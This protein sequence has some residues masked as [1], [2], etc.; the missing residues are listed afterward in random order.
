MTNQQNAKTE[1]FNEPKPASIRLWHW[2]AFLFFLASITTVIIGST[3]AVISDNSQTVL[4]K[5]LCL[6]ISPKAKSF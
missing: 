6:F 1:F 3:L 2:L 5:I 4:G